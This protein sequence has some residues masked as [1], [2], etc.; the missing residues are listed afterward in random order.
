[1]QETNKLPSAEELARATLLGSNRR[2]MLAQL[3]GDAQA[4]L[5][6]RAITLCL[7]RFVIDRQSGA[8]VPY[9][10]ERGMERVLEALGAYYPEGRV[11][12]EGRLV[13]LRG[14]VDSSGVRVGVELGLGPAAQLVVSL[15][16]IARVSRLKGALQA[17]DRQ[18]HL[19][20]RGMGADYEL[21]AQGVNPRPRS[22][23]EVPLVPLTRHGVMGAHLGTS[24][25]TGRDLMRL[26]AATAIR[27]SQAGETAAAE[28]FR[29][30][31]ALSPVISF[32]TD[33]ALGLRGGNPHEAGRMIRTRLWR[34]ADPERSGTIPGCLAADFGFAAYGEW[35]ESVQAVLVTNDSGET[36]SCDKRLVEDVMSDHELDRSE[37]ASLLAAAHPLVRWDGQLEVRSADALP[38]RLACAY[39]AL[40]RSVFCDEKASEL[41]GILCAEANEEGVAD[42]EQDLRERG[43]DARV[44][45]RSLPNFVEQ[46]VDVA[47]GGLEDAADRAVLDE[48][49]QL[50]EIRTVPRDLL[51][52]TWDKAHVTGGK[53]G[54][55]EAGFGIA[56]SGATGTA[57]DAADAQ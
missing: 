34:E 44:Y 28:A 3:R 20:S 47:R 7:E 24:G 33:D 22:A 2:R 1:M 38:P 12:E 54:A 50:W 11:V 48:L 10:G 27:L 35:L 56:G 32:L 16:P 43:W 49:T 39:A 5:G 53:A 51:V 18:F 25:R 40:M 13:G 29:L 6:E 30:A 42:L 9:Q 21:L 8:T 57:V 4:H 17:V 36:T 52:D 14:S 26:T 37:V 23:A 31:S 46:L 19:A 45:G 55:A 41:A 15:G